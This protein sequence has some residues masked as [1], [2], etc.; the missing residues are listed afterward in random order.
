[1]GLWSCRRVWFCAPNQPYLYLFFVLSGS[2]CQLASCFLPA[3][4]GF[5]LSTLF[6]SALILFATSAF[7]L[8]SPKRL[9]VLSLRVFAP[10]ACT[11]VAHIRTLIGLASLCLVVP[12]PGGKREFL[13]W[14]F[15]SNL[16]S[17]GSH[18]QNNVPTELWEWWRWC[19]QSIGGRGPVFVPAGNT[20]FWVG[21]MGP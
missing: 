20:S 2:C 18:A 1:M 5:A 6:Y 3:P 7:C 9:T 16:C 13:F 8:R 21:R 12:D 4:A 15:T 17:C 19:Q 11:W 14:D 10:S